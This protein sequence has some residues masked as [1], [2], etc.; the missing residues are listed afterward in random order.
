MIGI[1]L[2][3][4]GYSNEYFH[5][6]MVENT[7]RDLIEKASEEPSNFPKKM[8]GVSWYFSRYKEFYHIPDHRMSNKEEALMKN[9][10]FNIKSC[11]PHLKTVDFAKFVTILGKMDAI[12]SYKEHNYVMRV[13]EEK[14]QKDLS[15]FELEQWNSVLGGFESSK[16]YA[17]DPIVV[18][19]FLRL[20]EEFALEQ[21][22]VDMIQDLQ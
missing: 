2:I 21:K 3:R 22:F 4:L 15:S 11:L 7:R 13:L 6:F 14:L 18:K 1:S 10:P 12:D 17:R 8:Y 20:S 9:L 16:L 5:R 19:D